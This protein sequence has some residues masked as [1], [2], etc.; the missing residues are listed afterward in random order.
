VIVVGLSSPLGRQLGAC[1]D[2][3]WARIIAV[4]IRRRVRVSAL[5]QDRYDEKKTRLIECDVHGFMQR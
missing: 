2:D 4:V 5:E 3:G 1:S